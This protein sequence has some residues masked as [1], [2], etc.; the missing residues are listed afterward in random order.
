V[1]DRGRSRGARRAQVTPRAIVHYYGPQIH[2]HG[3][4][5]EEAA[6]RI[7]CQAIRGTAGDAIT[8]GKEP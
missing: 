2:I 8:E 3:R 4:D 5:D 7:I 1:A 6:A